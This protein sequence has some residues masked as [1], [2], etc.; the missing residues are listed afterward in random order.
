M[1][2]VRPHNPSNAFDVRHLERGLL[3]VCSEAFFFFFTFFCWK[4][5]MLLTVYDYW[6]FFGHSVSLVCSVFIFLIYFLISTSFA[7]FFRI[8][9]SISISNKFMKTTKGKKKRVHLKYYSIDKT[10]TRKCVIRK[11]N[12]TGDGLYTLKRMTGQQFGFQKP[13]HWLY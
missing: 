8:Q 13:Y 9:N 1:A 2:A 11:A 3:L 4:L 6:L 5:M 10:R 7:W 12:S